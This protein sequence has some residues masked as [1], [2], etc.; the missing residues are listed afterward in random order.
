L[1]WQNG[2]VTDLGSL[3]SLMSNVACA[4]NNRGQVVGVSDLTGDATGYAFLWE[5][6]AMTDLGT[7][8]GDF[9]SVAFSINNKGQVVGQSCDINVNCRAALWE[10]DVMIDLNTVIAPNSS[11]YLLSANDIN[12][13][14]SI[15]GQALDPS[16]GDTPAFL[17]TPTDDGSQGG[18][19]YLS[20]RSRTS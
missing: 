18:S 8:P 2:A 6:V 15:V 5:N 3:G 17:A 14:G 10:N 19:R 20:G 1:L 9:S 7:L 16:T 12:D 13:Q 4:I 11:L